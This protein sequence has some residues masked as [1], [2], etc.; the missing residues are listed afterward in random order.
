MFLYFRM[1]VSIVVN[2]FTVRVLW[3]VLGVND[4]GI[5]NVVGGIVL[6]FI[7]LNNAMIASSQ[8][9][10]SYGLGK[11]DPDALRRTFSISITVH[12]LLAVAV[13]IIA[14]T[15]G[16]WFLN[17]KLNIPVERMVAANWVYQSAVIAFIINMVSVPYNACIVAHEHMDVYGYLGILEVFLK[18]GIVLL[19][20]V[21][22]FDRLISYAI[23]LMM[24]SLVM[25]LIYSIYCKK[26][27]AECRYTK[28][29]DVGIMKE[30]FSFAGW[31]LI[32]NM[33]FSVREQGL[34]I[35]LNLFFN[36]AVN[37]AKGIANQIGS[38]LNGFASSFTM[39]V[40]PQI[41]K[42]YAAGETASMMNLM[43]SGCK[44]S[45]MLMAIIVLPLTAAADTVLHIWLGNVAPYTVGFLQLVLVMSLIDCVVSPIVTAMQATGNIRKFQIVISIIMIANLP[46]AWLWLKFSSN[47]Y[48]VM[49]VSI[50]TSVIG[51][52]ARLMLLHELIP[53]SYAEFFR[54]VYGRTLPVII[55]L[56][57]IIF[58]IEP[59]FASNL[60][61]LVLFALSSV[62]IIAIAYYTLLLSSAERTFLKKALL[63]K[64]HH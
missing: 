61:G 23:L 51:L 11:G 18:L 58:L 10:I 54:K 55:L 40:N 30:M 45:L 38:V 41:T 3:Q 2:I 49:Y 13:L 57:V 44:Y 37:A 5:Y 17:A 62:I 59:F 32:G 46:I 26:H 48:I 64:L 56:G 34:N 19:V 47:P 35:V 21:L 20:A 39:A 28:T 24:V 12:I 31:S 60:V 22:P 36:V 15:V 25:R 7:F 9:F 42:R 53:F 43:F 4:Y 27:F 50:A 16:L 8:R 6:M 63:R 1:I 29:K 14:E 52:V 33:G